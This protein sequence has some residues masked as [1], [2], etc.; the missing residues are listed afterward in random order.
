MKEWEAHVVQKH[1]EEET[2]EALDRASV[3]VAGHFVLAAGG[4]TDVKLEMDKL[5]KSP[6]DLRVVL[7]LLAKFGDSL[8][9]DVILGVPS[10]GQLLAEEISKLD[11]VAAPFVEIERVPAGAKQDFRYRDES[12]ER[13]AMEAERVVIYEDVVSTMSSIAGVVRLLKLG[14]LQQDIHSVAIWRRGVLTPEY[15]VGVTPHFLVEEEIPIWTEAECP[16]CR[17]L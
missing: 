3:R 16:V 10:G 4:H 11:L 14:G 9:P 8:H 5:Q 13:L 12:G 1:I 2:R 17:E 6:E 15:S 7:E